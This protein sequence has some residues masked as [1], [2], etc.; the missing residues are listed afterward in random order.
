M[1]CITGNV[2]KPDKTSASFLSFLGY[3]DKRVQLDSS[4][5]RGD[6]KYNA[7]LSMMA[8]K[9]S[10]ENKAYI[11]AILKD[12]WNVCMNQS[13]H[14]NLLSFYDSILLFY[15][16]IN[17]ILLDRHIDIILCLCVLCRWSS[18]VFM[19]SGMV[20]SNLNSSK[21]SCLIWEITILHTIFH[22]HFFRNIHI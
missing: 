7:A 1:I 16:N 22:T 18:W 5:E 2:V 11:E 10:Y 15:L 19:T 9:V 17:T 12:H 4:I 13:L 3:W 6:G 21:Y 20:R 8:S 14:L